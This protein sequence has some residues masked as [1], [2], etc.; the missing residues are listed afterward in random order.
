M[1]ERDYDE[2]QITLLETYRSRLRENPAADP[3]QELD[4]GLAEVARHLE[5][6][7]GGPNPDPTITP[8]PAF[9]ASLRQ[10]ILAEAEWLDS[11]SRPASGAGVDGRARN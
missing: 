8:D 4:P 6:D 3:P 9:V 11:R 10:R 2:H 7:M 1:S 5:A